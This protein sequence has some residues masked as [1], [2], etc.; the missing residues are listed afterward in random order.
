MNIG[1]FS[2]SGA[3]NVI[4]FSVNMTG[5]IRSATEGRVEELEQMVQRHFDAV[6]EGTG[7]TYGYRSDWD[8]HPY[9]F[10]NRSGIWQRL[11]QAIHAAGMTPRGLPSFGGSDANI[12]NGKGIP[13]INLGTGAQN[14]HSND[15]FILYEDLIN[16]TKIALE[17]MRHEK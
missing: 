12:L 14:P 10:D 9:S 3:T 1:P 13:T 17:L 4:P 5:E 7:A 11:E 8:F 15:E 16:T 6:L 2:S